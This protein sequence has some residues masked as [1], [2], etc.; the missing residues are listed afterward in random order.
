[1]TYQAAAFSRQKQLVGAAA[2]ERLASARVLLCG[3]GGVGSWAAEA[4]TRAALGH[5]TLVDHDCIQ[6]SNLNRQLH[7]LHSTLGRSKVACMRERLLD[8][9]PEAKIEALQLRLSPANCRQLLESQ[10]WDYVIDA[11]D[12]RQA[13]LALLQNCLEMR[14]PLL[15]SMGSANKL[16]A[17]QIKIGDISQTRGCPMARLLRKN[18]RKA[19]FDCALTVI[20][21]EELPLLPQTETEKAEAP[22]EKRPLGTISY[23]PALFGLKAAAYV[24]EKLLDS[25]SYP[26]RGLDI[27]KSQDSE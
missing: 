9:S 17:E 25:E 12:E 22:G 20:Y 2:M 4:L 7:S 19:G 18:L 8:I 14:L 3:L 27:K 23:M 16:H 1:M 26:R 13:K 15:S 5:L 11:I 6:P 21:S 24:L 10:P